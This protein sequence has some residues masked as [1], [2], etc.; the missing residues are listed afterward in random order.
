[1]TRILVT[2]AT[3]AVGAHVVRALQDHSAD[4]TVLVR[5]PATAKTRLGDVRLAPG[6]FDDPGSLRR[7]LSGV[8]RVYLSAADGPRKV[9][10]E[11]AVIDAAAEAGVQRIVKLSAMHAD[12]ASTLPAYRWHG[13]IEEHL[14]RSPVPAVILRPA[15]FMTNLLMVAAGV[16]STGLLHAPTD[17]RPVAM[18][19]IRD[20]AETAAVTLLADGHTGRTYDLT[21]PSAITFADVAAALTDATGSPVRSVDLTGEQA[22]PRFEGNG[23]PD[24]LAAHLAGVFGVIRAGGFATTTGHV[25]A[26]TGHPARGIAAFT[27]DFAAAFTP[28]AVPAGQHG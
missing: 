18:I 16:A 26:I 27:R 5:D 14:R 25:E 10:H 11:T 21:G 6:D 2:G 1:M 28:P 17:G 23:L 22:R 9:A 4:I 24:W 12:P 8:E 20:I 7:A 15:F 19:D 3:G 13:E